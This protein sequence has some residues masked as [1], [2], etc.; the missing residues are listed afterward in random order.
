M[1]R[2]HSYTRIQLCTYDIAHISNASI[3][4]YY[5]VTIAA[6]SSPEP[7]L[8]DAAGAALAAVGRNKPL[9]GA[10]G[11]AWAWP[12]SIIIGGNVT[13]FMG[14][15]PGIPPG[16]IPLIPCKCAKGFAFCVC[17]AVVICDRNWW[18]VAIQFAGGGKLPI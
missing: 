1:R 12:F 16:D 4:T 5:T 2:A 8:G 17:A 18:Y 15:I 13:P 14:G 10:P 3:P 9:F 11:N 6:F 7:E